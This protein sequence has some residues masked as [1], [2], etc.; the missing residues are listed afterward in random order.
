MDPL[1]R[2]IEAPRVTDHAYPTGLALHACHVLGVSPAVGE[3]DLD[4]DVLAGAHA[5]DCLR[6]V[7]LRGGGEDHG[8]DAR[9]VEYLCE[10]RGGVWNAKPGRGLP[11]L[12]GRASDQGDDFDAADRTDRLEMFLTECAGAREDDFHYRAP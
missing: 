2:W 3:R 10:L 11:G 4:L 9:P 7:Q 8:V 1:M 6:R 12:L 5:L